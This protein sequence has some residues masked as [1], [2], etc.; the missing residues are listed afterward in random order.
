[1]AGL[2]ADPWVRLTPRDKIEPPGGAG[3]E[4][5]RALNAAIA[6]TLQLGSVRAPPICSMKLTSLPAV[7]TPLR[8][9]PSFRQ[10]QKSTVP[11]ETRGAPYLAHR[12]AL[13]PLFPDF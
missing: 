13:N 12:W 9:A 8:S 4:S 5:Q 10:G 2:P 7:A 11:A 3:Q 6:P 1:M